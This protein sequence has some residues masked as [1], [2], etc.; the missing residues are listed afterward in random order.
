MTGTNVSNGVDVPGTNPLNGRFTIP[1]FATQITIPVEVLPDNIL[2]FGGETVTVT[3]DG[4]VVVGS[5]PEITPNTTPATVTI[6][7]ETFV[8]SIKAGD[9]PALE[10]GASNGGNNG[11]FVVSITN[12]SSQATEVTYQILNT[13][14]DPASLAAGG[15]ANPAD[16]KHQGLGMASPSSATTGTVTIPAGKVSALIE[17]DVLQDFVVEGDET[18]KIKLISVNGNGNGAVVL[19]DNV[20]ADPASPVEATLTILDNDIAEVTVTA[21]DATAV[22]PNSG[23][24][25]DGKFQITMSKIS[26]VDVKVHYTVQTG[27]ASTVAIPT[28]DYTGIV[29]GS[30]VIPAGSQTAT[31]QLTS[32]RIRLSN[33]TKRSRLLWVKRP[34]QT[35]FP[36]RRDRPA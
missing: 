33:K 5:D 18:V 28:S 29:T 26:D 17:I 21:V 22:E 14:T 36:S 34:S 32:T 13:G 16:Y 6:S 30:V 8:V 12:P 35:E 11:A 25:P 2:E 9:T 20:N 4:S 7:D 24:T 10:D 1:A 15:A 3:L 27:P 19:G 23:S 31:F